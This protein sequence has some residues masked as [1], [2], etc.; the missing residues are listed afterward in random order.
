[1]CADTANCA[2][3]GGGAGKCSQS[4]EKT[5]FAVLYDAGICA[6]DIVDDGGEEGTVER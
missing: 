3:C 5:L 6:T 2:W 4:L 1:V